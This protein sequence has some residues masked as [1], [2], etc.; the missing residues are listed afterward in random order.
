MLISAGNRACGRFKIEIQ[1]ADGNRRGWVKYV[2]GVDRTKMG[3]SALLGSLLAEARETDLPVGSVIV[4]SSPFG[5]AENPYNEIKIYVVD[6]QGRM[7]PLFHSET[8]IY[9]T[10]VSPSMLDMV[11]TALKFRPRDLDDLTEEESRRLL[12][13]EIIAT[14]AATRREDLRAEKARITQRLAEIDAE[15]AT[16]E[17][18]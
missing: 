7:A 1:T 14:E 18:S 12:G 16:L 13:A 6:N 4:T 11:E 8:L 5:S 15:L 17:R 10:E 3:D 9:W 2:V